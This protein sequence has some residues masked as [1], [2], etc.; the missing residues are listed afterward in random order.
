MVVA[1]LHPRAV[2]VDSARDQMQVVVIFVAGDAPEFVAFGSDLA[3]STVAVGAGGAGRHRGL[4]PSAHRVPLLARNRAV[5]VARRRPPPQRI[6]G[7]TP[8][9]A[10]GQGFLDQLA[11]V[12]PRQLMPTAVRVTDRQQLPARVV[13]VIGDQAVGIDR[14]G[15]IPFSVAPPGPHCLAAGTAVQETVAVLVG[16]R[17]VLRRKQ[18]HQAS[19]FVVAVLGDRAQRILLGDQATRRVIDLEVL[20]TIGLDLAHQPCTVVVDVGLFAAIDVMH[21][22]AAVI[23][24]DVTRVHLRKRRPV[25]HTAR[26]F[27][28]ALPLPEETR[29][30]GQLPLQDDVGVVV[31]VTLAVTDSVGRL[32]QAL[33]GVVAVAGEGLFGVPA[34]PVRSEGLIVDGNQMRPLITQQQRPP[35]AIV[36]ANHPLLMITRNPQAI[37]IRIT[38]RRQPP[39]AKVIKPRHVPGQRNNQFLRLIPQKNRRP[40]QA[41]VNRRPLDT[42]QRKSRATVFVIDPDHRIAIE[43]QP[44]RQRVAPAKAQPDINLDGTG[45][46]QPGELEWQHPIE[47][48]IAQG[49]QFFAG[50]HR[51]RAA[52]GAGKRH[53]IGAVAVGVFRLIRS[54]VARLVPLHP[55]CVSRLVPRHGRGVRHGQHHRVSLTNVQRDRRRRLDRHVARIDH[56]R[57]QRGRVLV[58]IGSGGQFGQ[59]QR[60]RCQPLPRPWRFDLAQHFAA[61]FQRYA[62]A[63][64]DPH[65]QKADQ[66]LDPDFGHHLRQI[67]RRQHLQPTGKR[68]QMDKQQRLVTEDQQATG[69]GFTGGIEQRLQFDLGQVLQQFFTVGL[70]VGEQGEQLFNV[71]PDVVQGF[72]EPA[73]V[74]LLQLAVTIA[75]TGA[76]KLR[77]QRLKT[78]PLVAKP[79]LQPIQNPFVRGVQR[80]DLVGGNIRKEGDAITL[81]PV[82]V[83]DFQNAARADGMAQRGTEAQDPVDVADHRFE[84]HRGI[85]DRYEARRLEQMHQGQRAARRAHDHR[86]L[87]GLAG[88][89]GG[90]EV[91]VVADLEHLLDIQRRPRPELLGPGLVVVQ[92]QAELADQRFEVR[93]F[94]VQGGNHQQADAVVQGQ[95]PIG[96]EHSQALAHVK[97]EVRG[98]CGGSN[99]KEVGQVGIGCRTF[100]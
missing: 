14:F 44:M 25:P 57:L 58:Q 52:V 83:A 96:L 67:L 1:V 27:A 32:Q 54:V 60:R 76:G 3:V 91:Q 20:T 86:R 26:G 17:L 94:R 65:Q 75:E 21:G 98:L 95:K 2:G 16:R 55:G 78:G 61:Q 53:T 18:R 7:K 22:D 51:H 63:A 30:A 42:G 74:S 90:A 38:D 11:E 13:V 99:R 34:S 73:P 49:Q 12:I 84:H 85:A 82:A 89:D 64:R 100:R 24:P 59:A 80:L 31:V 15:D 66:Q 71:V 56:Q 92:A 4:H 97:K 10:V 48:T 62:N 69:D 43:R 28:R 46:I 35:R 29:A 72:L 40:R 36:E 45:A 5:F 68:C 37:A 19:D 41:V 6:V 81:A 9:A 50:D 70:Q 77:P 47:R 8:H 79:T 88:F 33:T 93:V 23:R 87:D 39:G